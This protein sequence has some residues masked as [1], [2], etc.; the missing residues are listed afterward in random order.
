MAMSTQAHLDS[1]YERHAKLEE[2]LNH[3]YF[4]HQDERAQTIKKQKLRV[5][6]EINRMLH[7]SA[8]QSLQRRQ[9]A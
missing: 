6:D 1:L 3:A 5:K 9:A 2:E 7:V 4:H 8:Q